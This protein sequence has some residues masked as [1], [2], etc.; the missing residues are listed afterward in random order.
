VGSR[1]L[2]VARGGVGVQARKEKL[3]HNY[4]CHECEWRGKTVVDRKQNARS[5]PWSKTF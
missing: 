5:D 4:T 3:A 1:D 2:D